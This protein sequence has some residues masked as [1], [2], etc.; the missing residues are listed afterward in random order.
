MYGH[1]THGGG[2]STAT[3]TE[4]YVPRQREAHDWRT[5]ADEGWQQAAAA[6]Q[7]RNTGTTR[8]GL[9]KRVPMDQLVPGGVN[10]AAEPHKSR[11][12]P[13]EVRG[14]LSAYH[15]GVQRGRASANDLSTIVDREGNQGGAR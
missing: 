10:D 9:P 12:T 3:S 1:P 8:S 2:Y 14:L 13:E 15:R 5:L 11:R 4:A 6:A 7:P